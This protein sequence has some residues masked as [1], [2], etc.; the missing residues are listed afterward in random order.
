LEVKGGFQSGFGG[1]EHETG[2]FVNLNNL[3]QSACYSITS[4]RWG[5]GLG[6]GGGVS[7]IMVFNSNAINWLDGRELS[8]W[9]FNL[10]LGENWGAVAKF[11]V[12][13]NIH[14]ML[15]LGAKSAIELVKNADDIKD[16]T[17]LVFSSLDLANSKERHPIFTFDVPMASVGM[18]I[19]GFK[20]SGKIH[21]DL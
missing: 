8:D 19:S 6:G 11:M 15:K 13:K 16:F 14:T 2:R 5:I 10:S 12:D 21:I 9:S 7:V 4:G 20:K 3:S 1:V 17:S 18:E